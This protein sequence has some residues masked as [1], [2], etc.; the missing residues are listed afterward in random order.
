MALA[1]DKIINVGMLYIQRGWVSKDEYEEYVKYLVE[2]YK[3]M[4]GNGVADRIAT[5]VGTLPFRTMQFSE[6]T[7]K[8]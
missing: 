5:D 7:I 4:G 2:P 1:Y 6:V 3:K 8:E